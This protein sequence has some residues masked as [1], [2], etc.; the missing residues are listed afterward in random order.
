MA[1]CKACYSKCTGAAEGGGPHLVPYT[2]F[3]Q[4]LKQML[5]QVLLGR[6]LAG[7]TKVQSQLILSQSRERLWEW[8][9]L[10]QVKTFQSGSKHTRVSEIPRGREQRL[11]HSPTTAAPSFTVEDLLIFF[12]DV[13]QQLVLQLLSLASG[14]SSE[15]WGLYMH[16]QTRTQVRDIHTYSTHT[17]T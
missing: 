15:A 8:A 10:N 4:V 9:W 11:K 16:T 12:L 3:S 5:V 6:E 17:H 13:K 1:T 2:A 14:L 7:A